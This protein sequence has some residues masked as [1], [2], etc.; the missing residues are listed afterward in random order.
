MEVGPRR[1]HQ[2]YQGTRGA[3]FVAGGG[4]RDCGSGGLCHQRDLGGI[5]R[6]KNSSIGAS[7]LRLLAVDFCSFGEA[8]GR[9]RPMGVEKGL[10]FAKNVRLEMRFALILR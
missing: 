9:F 8:G 4:V 2:M 10:K 3:R 7:G 1:P 5:L 6:G